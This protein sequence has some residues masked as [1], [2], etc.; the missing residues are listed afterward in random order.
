MLKKFLPTVAVMQDALGGLK[1]GPLSKAAVRDLVRLGDAARDRRDWAGAASY[2]RD[3]LEAV[4]KHRGVAIQLGHALKEMGDYAAAGRTYRRVLAVTPDDDDLH[5]QI[6]HLEK[7]RGNLRDA[8]QHYE[9]ASEINPTNLN[10]AA[11]LEMLRARLGEEKGQVTDAADILERPDDTPEH[12]LTNPLTLL[13]AGDRA[14]DIGDWAGAADRYAAYLRQTPLDVA[15]WVQLGNC[16]KDSGALVEAEGAYRHALTQTPHD[17]DIYLQLGH[18]LKLRGKKRE[19][20]EAYEQ[21]FGLAP[22]RA[23]LRELHGLRLSGGVLEARPENRVAE[24]QLEIGDLLKVMARDATMTGIQRVQLG[25]LTYALTRPES[26]AERGPR[27]VAWIDCQLWVLPRNRLVSL[28]A[29]LRTDGAEGHEERRQ[30]IH[31][32]EDHSILFRPIEG[33]VVVETGATWMQSNLSAAHERLK[34]NGVRLGLCLYDFIPITHPEFCHPYLTDAFGKAISVALAHADF[35]IP[36]SDFVRKECQHL[37]QEGGYPEMPMQT[38]P[39]AHGLIPLSEGGPT[40][41]DSWGSSIADLRG[42][43]YVLAV[44]SLHAHKNHILLVRSWQLLIREG[45]E[46]PLLVIAGKRGHGVE[47]LF[48]LLEATGYLGGRVEVIEDLTDFEIETLYRNCLFTV[49]PSFV[50]GWGLP[51]GESLAYGKVCV[52]SDA[53]SIPEVGGDFVV[54]IDPYNTRAAAK[55]I[56]QLLQDRPRLAA[57]QAKIRTD[58]RVRDWPEYGVAF[59]RTV[60]DLAGRAA[61]APLCVPADK[62]LLPRAEPIGWA[63]GARL[64]ARAEL[65]NRTYGQMILAQGWHPAEAWGTW[66]DGAAARIA[67]ITDAPAKSAVRIT[68]QFRTVFWPRRNKVTLRAAGSAGHTMIVPKGAS[69]DFLMSMIC[70]VDHRGRLEIEILLQGRVV[71]EHNPRSLGLGLVRLMYSVVGADDEVVPPCVLESPVALSNRNYQ[72]MPPRE[73]GTLR[74]AIHRRRILGDGWGEPDASGVRLDGAVGTLVARSAAAPGEPVR[75]VIRVATEAMPHGAALTLRSPC[76]AQASFGLMKQAGDTSSLFWLDC[77]ADMDRRIELS[78]SLTGIYVQSGRATLCLKAF[79]YARLR[80]GAE[81]EALT[82]ALLFPATATG[83]GDEELV[84]DMR[85]TVMGH[86]KGSY[87]LAAVNRRLA[88]SLEAVRPGSVRFEQVETIPVRDLTD[89]PPTE[90]AGVAALVDRPLHDGGCEVIITQHYPLYVPPMPGDLPLTYIFWEESLLPRAVVAQLNASFRGV[91]VPARSVGKVLV[92]SGVRVPIRNVGF[93]P[94]LASFSALSARRR[95]GDG[96]PRGKSG[97]FTFLHVSSCF[98]RKGVDALLQAYLKAFRRGDA[99]R[100]VVKTFPNLHN[101]MA[102]DLARLRQEDPDMPRV[103]LIDRDMSR[104]ALLE[105]YAG[106]DAVVLPTRGEG[107]NIPAAEALAAGLPLIVTDFGAHLDFLDADNARLVDFSFKPAKSHLT[108]SGSMWADPD[109]AD[110]AA[111]MR[112]VRAAHEATK[113]RVQAG[114]AVAARLDDARDWG[115]RVVA[116]SRSLLFARTAAAPAVAWVSTWNVRCGIATYSQALLEAYEEAASKVVL[117]CDTR[118]LPADLQVHG[119]PGARRAWTIFDPA[120]METLADAIEATAA[121]V[122]V[123]QH[124]PGLIRWIDLATLLADE[125]LTDRTVVVTLHNVLDLTGIDPVERAQVVAALSRIAR[126][127]VHPVRDLNVLKS[128]GLIDNVT[129]FPHGASFPDIKPIEAVA[130][131]PRSSP[132]IG[133]YGFFLPH[134]GIATLIAAFAELK[135]E[136]PKARL[137]LVCAE[138]PSANSTDEIERCRADARARGIYD[139]IEW[140]TEFLSGAESLRLLSECDVV[141]LPY[142]KTPESAS[143]AVRVAVASRAPVIVTPQAIFDDMGDAVIRTSGEDVDAIAGGIAWLLNQPEARRAVQASAATWLA[144]HDWTVVADRLQGMLIGLQNERAA[145]GEAAERK[146]APEGR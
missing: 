34:Q 71:P 2:Y 97:D 83:P 8:L 74:E 64:P 65:L 46:P 26:G 5:L 77:K 52:A 60:R 116:A 130:L 141:A 98:P 110:L 144:E 9:L 132:M 36:I 108:S 79:A 106:A 136:W 90:R 86:A 102:A 99:V 4:P 38:V 54:Y 101:T 94:D 84:R 82:E 40:A 35:V 62:I 121:E 129:L 78:V 128:L 89:V 95:E 37:L 131:A 93:S 92:D 49:F 117:L 24:T 51:V 25:L 146:Q 73:L 16:L 112:E 6:G 142:E 138:Y 85:F 119:A 103:D 7:L 44:S 125:R 14:R 76:G 81:R 53:A 58:F 111:A 100:L 61:P 33:D 123:I 42:E 17:A 20:W 120:S 72:V 39:L 48:A 143:G 50:E 59:L 30:L 140:V 113:G 109:V 1:A 47:E 107:F 137:R 15:I 32:L 57:L 19:A 45:F 13:V 145:G 23:T 69:S 75:V 134:K 22:L 3:V 87:S 135:R 41:S 126:I 96:V 133:T 118:T 122:V 21:S 127:L 11:E 43:P 63:Y 105:L 104:R 67:F 18:A 80:S 27:F 66:M 139:S 115:Q 10:A 70:E 124:H 55:T 91:L 56:R 29:Q 68:L 12:S 88:M 31:R 28:I 114:L